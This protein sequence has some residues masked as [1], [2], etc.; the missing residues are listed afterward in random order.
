MATLASGHS[1][2]DGKGCQIAHAGKIRCKSG[3]MDEQHRKA[4]LKQT[5]DTV[6]RG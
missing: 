2:P 6:S 1:Q 3:I 5:F 4:L